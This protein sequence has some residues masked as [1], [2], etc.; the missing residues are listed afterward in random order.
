MRASVH[1]HMGNFYE[2]MYIHVYCGQWS[3]REVPNDFFWNFSKILIFGC[4]AAILRSKFE[5][6][7]K[8]EGKFLVGYRKG[9]MIKMGS[10]GL[11]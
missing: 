9:L 2:S 5:F 8:S 4:L 3:P 6:F 11:L 10:V 7:T 1:S